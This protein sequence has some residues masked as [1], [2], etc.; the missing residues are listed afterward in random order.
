M[1]A[2]EIEKLLCI[3]GTV[4]TFHIFSEFLVYNGNIKESFERRTF[5]ARVY[6]WQLE[7]FVTSID[8]FIY[9]FC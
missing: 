8:R 6:R 2:W 1:L 9:E 7:S 4:L 3:D 5:M